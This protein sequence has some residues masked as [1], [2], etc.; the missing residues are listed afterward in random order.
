[1]TGEIVGLKPSV[2]RTSPENRSRVGAHSGIFFNCISLF[3]PYIMPEPSQPSLVISNAL[4]PNVIDNGDAMQYHLDPASED[5]YEPPAKR[6]KG[7]GKAK[8]MVGKRNKVGE[9]VKPP[10]SKGV[11]GYSRLEREEG[12][13][14]DEIAC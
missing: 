10:P 1:M 9:I 14:I 6:S 12:E 5:G 3:I 13:S 7:K 4:P 8:K 11:D 2:I